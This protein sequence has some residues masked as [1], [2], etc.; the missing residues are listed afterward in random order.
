MGAQM[1][2]IQDRLSSDET[3]KAIKVSPPLIE[4][5]SNA[6]RLDGVNNECR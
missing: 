1:A 3:F 6:L 2:H 4:A 5:N